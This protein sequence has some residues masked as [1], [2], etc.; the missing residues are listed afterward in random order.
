MTDYWTVPMKDLVL[1]GPAI[2]ATTSLE[3]LQ[4][5]YRSPTEPINRRMRAA[6]AALPFEHPKLAVIARWDASEGI[7]AQLEA[8]IA[9]SQA[10]RLGLPRSAD[11]P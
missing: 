1:E 8:A 7:G 6:I 3:F 9:K 10:L 4:K 2:E 11:P 5:V